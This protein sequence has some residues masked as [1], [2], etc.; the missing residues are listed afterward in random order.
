MNII[1]KWS[2][3]SIV[4]TKVFVSR[5]RQEKSRVYYP[6]ILSPVFIIINSGEKNEVNIQKK[7]N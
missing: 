6:L 1:H 2:C 3:L 4:T 5:G 7:D